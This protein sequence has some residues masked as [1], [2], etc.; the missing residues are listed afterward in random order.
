MKKKSKMLM[1]G[2]IVAAVSLF[3]VTAFASTPN[4]TGYKAF[5]EMLKANP[6][7]GKTIQSATAN[8]SFTVKVDGETVLEAGG[9]MKVEN[10]GGASGDF[11]ITLMGVERSGSVYSSGDN[12]VYFVDQTHDLHYQ[13]INLGDEQVGKRNK[14]T[15]EAD[16]HHRPMNKA[17]EAFL[18][19]MV[20]N[21]KDNF[22][23]TNH[24]NGSRTIMLNVSKEEIPLPLRLL[25]DVASSADKN[26]RSHTEEVPAEWDRLQQ[27][28]FFQ[29]LAGTDLPEQLPKLTKDVVIEHVRLQLTVDANS[30]LQGVQGQ[31]EVSGKDEAGVTHRVEMAGAGN[32]S[33]INTTTPDLYDSA[34]KFVEIID[35]AAF[36]NRR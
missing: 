16:F 19:F 7:S 1:I 27:L 14:K 2:A 28:P 26:E 10:A 18:D 15:D 4:T 6:M 11:D 21:L 8:G 13:V 9:V 31:L 17:E 32:V 33:G 35:A 22:S 23:V 29:G 12:T 34:D 30:R 36:D 5:K 25:V 20:G 3:T 24:S